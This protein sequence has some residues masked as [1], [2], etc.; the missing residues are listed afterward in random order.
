MIERLHPAMRARRPAFT[1]CLS[2]L[3]LT[4]CQTTP[5]T[6]QDQSASRLVVFGDSLSDQ[7]NL[8]QL[9]REVTHLRHLHMG[10]PPTSHQGGAF[11]N[12]QLAV[13]FVATALG[14]RLQPAWRKSAVKSAKDPVK[15]DA[16]VLDMLAPTATKTIQWTAL[17][18]GPPPSSSAMRFK[19]VARE[20]IAENFAMSHPLGLNYAVAGAAIADDYSGLRLDLYNEVS[21]AKQVDAYVSRADKSAIGQS[22]FIFFLGGN[23]L[24]NVFADTR[25]RTDDDKRRKIASLPAI[26][27]NNIRRVQALGGRRILVIGPPDISLT[28]SMFDT[29]LAPLAQDLSRQLEGTMKTAL[30]EA[31]TDDGVLWLPLQGVFAQ[32]LQAWD[33]ATRHTGCVTDIEA[34]YFE[35]GPLLERE[36]LVVKFVNGCTQARLDRREFPFFDSV[37]PSEGIYEKF[38]QTILQKIRQFKP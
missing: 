37:H 10:F 3:L 25:L 8:M 18:S 31:F 27:V 20:K 35:L 36:E 2:L 6:P 21:L 16:D 11:S 24:L 23:D 12:G 32:W 9:A 22:I 34:G 7:G 17:T 29:P 28:P 5:A 33:P 30:D 26:M 13:E 38:G 15:L 14:D 19:A 1:L 4:G